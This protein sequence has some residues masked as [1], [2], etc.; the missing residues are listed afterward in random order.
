[1]LETSVIE[2]RPPTPATQKNVLAAS[3][4][5]CAYPGCSRRLFDVEHETLIGTVAHIH[6]RKQ[7][8]PRFDP[9]Q[10]EQENRSFPNLVGM[11]AEHSKII[12]GPKWEDFSPETLRTWKAEHEQ[13]VAEDAD[14][15][16]I[17]P[18][19]AVVGLN[20]GGKRVRYSFWVDQSGRPRMFRPEQLAIVNVLQSL[21][22]MMLKVTALP[23]RLQ[24]AKNSDV[25]TVLQQEWADLR[26]ST[27]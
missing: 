6:S 4:N 21:M 5:Q 3:G 26:L 1:M 20:L 11:C 24:E 18:P 8:G 15:S 16:W 19:N 25:A 2:H 10:S 23:G 27:L 22:L 7:N 17:R 9:M 12:D 14:R 13:R